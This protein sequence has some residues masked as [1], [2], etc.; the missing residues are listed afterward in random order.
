MEQPNYYS[1]IPAY[2][3]YDKELKPMEILMYGELSSLA[4]KYGYS[5]A[6]NGYFAEL[7]NVHKDTVS[8]WI[9]KLKDKGYLHVEIIRNENKEIVQRKIYITPPYSLNDREGYSTKNLEGI[10]EK[11]KGNTTRFNTTSNN[12][13]SAKGDCIQ[14]YQNEIGMLNPNQIQQLIDWVEDFNKNNEAEEIISEAIEQSV[15]EKAKSFAYLNN[16]LKR[17]AD[18]KV[19]TLEDAKKQSKENKTSYKKKDVDVSSVLEDIL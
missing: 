13:E 12:R 14:K 8:K 3:R 1:V 10:D 11:A 7:Y 9:K 16:K 6:T 5:F 18:A 19:E 17:Y 4:N 15:K 2:V